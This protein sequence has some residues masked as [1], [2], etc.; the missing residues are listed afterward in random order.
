[1]TIDKSSQQQPKIQKADNPLK[2]IAGKFGGE[3]WLKTQSEIERFRQKD[4]KE[5]EQL[6]DTNS[7]HQD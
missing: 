5:T 3:F 2:D 1:M 6:Q 7:N 4:R